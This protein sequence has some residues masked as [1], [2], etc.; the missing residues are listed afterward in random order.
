[1]S[2]TH[3]FDRFLHPRSVAVVGASPQAGTPRNALVRNLLKHGFQGTVYPVTPSHAQV[4]GLTAYRNVDELP[5]VPDVALVITPAHTVADVIAECG[6]KGIR[7]AVVFSAGFEEVE[8]GEE[9]AQALSAAARAHGVTVVGPNC[10][11]F[12][13]VREKAIMSFSGAALAIEEI[14]HAPIATFLR[15]DLIFDGTNVLAQ[16]GKGRFVKPNRPVAASVSAA[17]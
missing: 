15:G 7:N 13:S 17:A 9:H 14:R 8:G 5:D 4:E 3:P 12:W 11:G 10:N 2:D 1:M 6:R 16:P